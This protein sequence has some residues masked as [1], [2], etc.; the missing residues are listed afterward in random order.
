MKLWGSSSFFWHCFV[1]VCSEKLWL[2]RS[3]GRC[4]NFITINDRQLLADC[5]LLGHSI[6]ACR[7]ENITHFHIPVCAPTA[8]SR[9]PTYEGGRSWIRILGTANRVLPGTRA[10]SLVRRRH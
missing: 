8:H 9:G 6:P 7:N 4:S 10:S 1:H 2:L 3:Q 5:S